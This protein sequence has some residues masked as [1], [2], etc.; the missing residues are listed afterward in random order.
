MAQF[1]GL[2]D[3]FDGGGPGQSGGSFSGALGVHIGDRCLQQ[4]GRLSNPGCLGEVWSAKGRR[5]AE[6]ESAQ[7]GHP[8]ARSHPDNGATAVA[9]APPR[10]SELWPAHFL[11]LFGPPLSGIAMDFV[12]PIIPALLAA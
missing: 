8:C 4:L 6:L 9:L 7:P 3:M 1:E 11:A 5:L 10:G 2:K 12:N